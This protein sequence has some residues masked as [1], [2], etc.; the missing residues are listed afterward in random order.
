MLK[1]HLISL[2]LEELVEIKM[3][4]AQPSGI[5]GDAYTA[6]IPRVRL[7]Y[8]HLYS[9]WIS[10]RTRQRLLSYVLSLLQ[11][12]RYYEAHLADNLSTEYDTSSIGRRTS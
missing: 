12:D 3:N 8:R 6:E 10:H 2:Q 1:S 11:H 9:T 7:V 5:L 4:D